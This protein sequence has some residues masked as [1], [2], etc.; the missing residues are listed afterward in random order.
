MQGNVSHPDVASVAMPGVMRGGVSGETTISMGSMTSAQHGQVSNEM[1]HVHGNRQ[2]WLLTVT[3]INWHPWSF[4]SKSF[5]DL[6]FHVDIILFSP[7]FLCKIDHGSY[8]SEQ[9]QKKKFQR[10][11]LYFFLQKFGVIFLSL[12]DR[13]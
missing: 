11:E 5:C 1:H 8:E 10:P 13:F 7:L 3:H 4:H 2:V 9:K 12:E 6:V